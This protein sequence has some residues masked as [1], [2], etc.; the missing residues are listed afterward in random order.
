[1]Q[2]TGDG[3]KAEHVVYVIAIPANRYDLLCMEGFARALR[4]FLGLQAAP[5]FKAIRPANM[6]RINVSP[7][8]EGIRP[9]VVCAVLR[10]VQFD[11]RRYKSFIDLQ[12]KLHQNIC[13][14]RSYVAIGTHDLDAIEGPFRYACVRPTDIRFVPLTESG[15]RE[16]N[17]KELLDFYRTDATCKHIKPYTDLIYESELYPLVSD[18]Q[19]RVLSLPPIINSKHS[20]ITLETKNVLIECTATDLT[21]ANVVLDTMVAMFSEYCA[22]PFTAEEVEVFYESSQSLHITPKLSQRTCDTKMSDVNGILGLSLSAEEMVKLAERMQLGPCVAVDDCIRVTVPPSRSDILHPIDVVEDIGIAYGYNN[23]SVTVPSTVCSGAA[24]PLNQLADLLR[25]EIAQAGFMEML[26]HGLCSSAENFTSLKRA[27]RPAVL[28]SNPANIEYE[29]VRTTLMPGALK[30]LAYNESISHKDGVRLFEIS[31]VVEVTNNAIGAAN[32]RHVVALYSSLTAGFEVIHGLMD[33]VM[34]ALQI[35]PEA[36][37]GASSLTAQE[38][39]DR[40]RVSR[41]GLVY[42]VRPSADPVYFQGMAADVVLRSTSE[43]GVVKEQVVGSMGVVHPDVLRNFEITY[44]CSIM[45]M[46]L[47]MLV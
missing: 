29:V 28:L 13:R 8:V 22:V 32:V 27:V 1:M 25:I 44:P 19:D 21:K 38:I 12:D 41:A 5:A 33:K 9:F 15:T 7:S 3:S 17:G 6:L 37:Y 45:E 16:F 24:L 42:F 26:T 14:K 43:E 20:K 10:G 11:A 30:T 39:E 4:V 18:G 35:M 23:L 31:D 40:R 46:N 47:E 36:E 34:T 2:F